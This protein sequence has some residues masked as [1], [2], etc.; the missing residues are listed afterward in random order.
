MTL[1]LV[2]LAGRG[3]V[4]VVQSFLLNHAQTLVQG[5]FAVPRNVF[6][7]FGLVNV[8]RLE[9]LDLGPLAMAFKHVLARCGILAPPLWVHNA[10][11]L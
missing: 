6:V 11:D 9:T 7:D 3:S 4:L 8:G 10:I 2:V 1:V 5:V